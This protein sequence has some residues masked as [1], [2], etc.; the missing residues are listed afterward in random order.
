MIKNR[1]N[2]KFFFLNKTGEKEERE[3][4]RKK[5]HKMP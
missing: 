5:R 3:P 4:E 1:N 2:N